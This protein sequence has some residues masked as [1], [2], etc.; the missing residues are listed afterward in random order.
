MIIH[1]E[2]NTNTRIRDIDRVFIP[3]WNSIFQVRILVNNDRNSNQNVNKFRA[4]KK[5]TI[6]SLVTCAF[7]GLNQA[8]EWEIETD[9]NRTIFL[10]EFSETVYLRR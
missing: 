6:E 2:K 4:G 8:E 3:S 1:D 5:K 10:M 7:E 9:I